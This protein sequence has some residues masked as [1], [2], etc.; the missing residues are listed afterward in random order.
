[1]HVCVYV[2]MLTCTCKLHMFARLC[3]CACMC[4]LSLTV[5]CELPHSACMA[6]SLLFPVHSQQHSIPPILVFGPSVLNLGVWP[7][8]LRVQA[9]MV[10]QEEIGIY[11][12]R[13]VQMV[14]SSIR[15]RAIQ[16]FFLQGTAFFASGPRSMFADDCRTGASRRSWSVCLRTILC[17]APQLLS[18]FPHSGSMLGNSSLP[19]VRH[20]NHSCAGLR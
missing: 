18:P 15:L 3:M 13:T 1:M 11:F 4:A 9:S 7:S 10:Q 2:C 20:N 5:S 19:Q 16:T 14:T 6:G 17:L 12:R 8:L